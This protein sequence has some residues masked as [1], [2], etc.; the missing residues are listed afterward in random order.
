MRGRGEGGHHLDVCAHYLVFAKRSELR[1][2][3]HRVRLIAGIVHGRR[4]LA[5][6]CRM[7]SNAQLFICSYA[8]NRTA[9][10]STPTIASVVLAESLL[11]PSSWDIVLDLPV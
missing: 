9:P 11:Q 1:R 3:W 2:T 10:Y 8:M 7:C 6:C 4:S 5:N